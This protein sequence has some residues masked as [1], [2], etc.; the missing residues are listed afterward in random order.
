[1]DK[2]D[3]KNTKDKIASEPGENVKKFIEEEGTDFD[4]NLESAKKMAEETGDRGR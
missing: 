2:Q 3:N 1:M 4:D